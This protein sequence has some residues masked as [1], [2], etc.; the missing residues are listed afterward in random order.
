V[1]NVHENPELGDTGWNDRFNARELQRLKDAGEPLPPLVREDEG[2]FGQLEDRDVE[3]QY[4]AELE[5]IEKERPDLSFPE[6][7]RLAHDLVSKRQRQS[8]KNAG[9]YD[10]D[11]RELARVTQDYPELSLIERQR[12]AR[13]RIEQRNT[14]GDA[15]PIEKTAEER[16]RAYLGDESIPSLMSSKKKV[17][18]GGGA[19]N[20]SV[21]RRNRATGKDEQVQLMGA[22][23][24]GGGGSSGRKR[25]KK[26]GTWICQLCRLEYCEHRPKRAAGRKPKDGMARHV[27]H[28]VRLSDGTL[29]ELHALGLSSGDA[30]ALFA[31]AYR[32]RRPLEAVIDEWKAAHP[33]PKI[34]YAAA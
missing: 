8:P 19:G 17:H 16:S 22:K 6:Q 20:K 29:T 7:Q 25:E 9:A 26:K 3:E 1:F 13:E 21:I 28:R 18:S 23:S 5:R 4:R 24:S 34:K 30:L 15:A 27:T 32:E 33:S 12:L 10:D 31:I 11:R 2:R 14:L